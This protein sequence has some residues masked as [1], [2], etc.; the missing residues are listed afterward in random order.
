MEGNVMSIHDPQQQLQ[1]FNKTALQQKYTE[2][3]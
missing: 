2:S 1:V 3:W